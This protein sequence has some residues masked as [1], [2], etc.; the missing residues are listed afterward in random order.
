MQEQTVEH[1]KE[2]TRHFKVE[3][4]KATGSLLSG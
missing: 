1:I 3:L 2:L 4:K